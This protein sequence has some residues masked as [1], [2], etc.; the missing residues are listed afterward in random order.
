MGNAILT[1]PAEDGDWVKRHNARKLL[2]CER[3]RDG[4]M[5][6]YVQGKP[7]P[8]PNITGLRSFCCLE[9]GAIGLCEK[10]RAICPESGSPISL[11]QSPGIL[12]DQ[13]PR[14]RLSYRRTLPRSGPL[15][16]TGEWRGKGYHRRE[17]L[18]LAEAGRV[19]PVFFLFRAA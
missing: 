18:S 5:R 17:Y 3:W 2:R 12:M 1:R 10:L 7:V 19:R 8:F 4:R 15:Q 14:P 6:L 11:P 9:S 16:R 13:K